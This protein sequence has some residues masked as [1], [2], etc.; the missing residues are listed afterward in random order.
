MRFQ[1]IIK[2]EKTAKKI[3]I[4]K[5]TSMGHYWICPFHRIDG[6]IHARE[7]VSPA[8]V[9]YAIR[10][11]VENEDPSNSVLNNFDIYVLPNANPDG[12]VVVVVAMMTPLIVSSEFLNIMRSGVFCS[13]ICNWYRKYKSREPF[14]N[15]SKQTVKFLRVGILLEIAIFIHLFLFFISLWVCKGRDGVFGSPN[16]NN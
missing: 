3:Q 16:C 4:Y 8:S 10:E 15:K 2:N 6:G 11:L 9:L 13:F 1:V 14:C 5:Y 7:W 12:W